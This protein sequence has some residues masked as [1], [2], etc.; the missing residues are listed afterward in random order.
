MLER[1]NKK[2]IKPFMIYSF[3]DFFSFREKLSLR[4]ACKMFNHCIMTTMTFLQNKNFVAM[5]KNWLQN[6]KEKFDNTNKKREKKSI[7]NINN[8]TIIF[9]SSE[10]KFSKKKTLIKLI[11]SKNFMNI[12]KQV[13]LGQ[14]L[15]PI[16]LMDE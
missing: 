14:M 9:D 1:K 3:L 16:N 12:K 7:E 4:L 11:N 2:K 13:R 5:N 8:K 10:K 15:L 6:I